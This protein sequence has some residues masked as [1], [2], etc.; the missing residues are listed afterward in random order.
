MEQFGT[1]GAFSLHN[2][3]AWPAHAGADLN[4]DKESYAMLHVVSVATA[5]QG[6]LYQLFAGVPPSQVIAGSGTN[7]SGLSPYV[8]ACSVEY[9][10]AVS[11]TG[12]GCHPK[13]P[14]AALQTVRH[15]VDFRQSS[16]GRLQERWENADAMGYMP[17]SGVLRHLPDVPQAWTRQSPHCQRNY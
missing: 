17:W 4:I 7:S 15:S 6:N 11:S 2:N 16:K 12:W 8:R 14:G 1:P 5:P 3:G 10:R 9:C 13:W